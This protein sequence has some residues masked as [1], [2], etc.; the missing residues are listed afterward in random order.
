MSLYQ[1]LPFSLRN[2]LRPLSMTSFGKSN[3]KL[4]AFRKALMLNGPAA[5]FILLLLII[6]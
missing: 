2:D 4:C 3:E 6:T 5:A 1:P